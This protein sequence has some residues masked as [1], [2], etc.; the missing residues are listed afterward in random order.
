M[1]SFEDIEEIIDEWFSDYAIEGNVSVAK[2]YTH[3]DN[4]NE[5]NLKYYLDENRT[6]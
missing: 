2:L 3:I 5:K 1:T 4:L 6:E